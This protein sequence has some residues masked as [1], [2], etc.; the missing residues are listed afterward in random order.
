MEPAPTDPENERRSARVL[1]QAARAVH[2]ESDPEAIVAWVTVHACEAVG[3][4][5]AGVLLLPDRDEGSARWRVAGPRAAELAQ[6]DGRLQTLFRPA[7][8]QAEPVHLD[9]GHWSLL[10]V[11]VADRDGRP[12]GCLVVADHTDRTF[13]PGNEAFV[14][15]LGAH[16]GIALD[17]QSS[18][19][20]L[21]GLEA[22]RREVVNQLQ[23]A[24]R[25]PRPTVP[26]TELGVHYVAADPSAPTGGDLYDWTL[27]PN[28]DLHLACVDIMGK[29][30]AATKDAVA[31]TH[32]LRLLVLDGCPLEQVVARADAIV[33]AQNPELVATVLVASYTPSTGILRIAG[34]GHPPPL[35]VSGDKVRELDA[36]G[37]PIGWPGAG[38]HEVVIVEL[39]RSDTLLLYTDGLIE[40]GRDIIAGLAQLA[41]LAL[42]TAEYPAAHQA[43]VLVERVLRDAPRHD[44]SLALILRRRVPPADEGRPPLGPFEYRFTPR[45]ASIPLARH[46]LRDWLVRAPVEETELDDLLL[47]ATELCANAVRHASGEP[48]SVSLRALTRDADVVIEMEDD[49]KGFA[50]DTSVHDE[51]PEVEAERGRGLFLVSALC[52]EVDVDRVD[53]RT[54]VRCV[55][56]AVLP[57][58]A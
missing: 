15:A 11:A 6:L 32:A 25:P 29:G 47:V 13:S 51:L 54:V 48:G 16:L 7:L 34:G 42:E 18:F 39:D 14:E 52:D 8:H 36:P 9:D 19:D 5:A 45:T 24:V 58:S 30:V 22:S 46:F 35:L 56:R 31:V 12:T 26:L 10:A 2:G 41:D 3:A 23:E 44:D 37:I 40:T 33:T 4:G 57:A 27:L 43:R 50:L 28:G 53:G 55:R 17:N 49:G 1:A 21:A 20:R 38:S